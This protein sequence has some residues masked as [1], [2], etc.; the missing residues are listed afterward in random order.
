MS[1]ESVWRRPRLI[2]S[3]SIF[4]A[5]PRVI[6]PRL[7]A[8]STTSCSRSRLSVTLRSRLAR[9]SSTL[10]SRPV[11]PRA[12]AELFSPLSLSIS[13]FAFFGAL[14]FLAALFCAFAFLAFA[15]DFLEAFFSAIWSRL[16][17]A[18]GWGDYLT[19]ASSVVSNP[20]ST[21]AWSES[22]RARPSS[23]DL[24]PL[25]RPAA[26]AG[27]DRAM[28][29]AS[30][31]SI[32]SG[33]V[34]SPRPKRSASSS[35]TSGFWR[36]RRLRSPPK[37]SGASPANSIA[38][39]AASRTS[40]TASGGSVVGGVQVGDADPGGGAGQR[41]RPA[42]GP[43]L[44]DREP[45]PLDDP[46]ER[47]AA[48]HE[49]EVGAALAGGDQVR[50]EAGGRRAQG[51][52]AVARGQHPVRLGAAGL[53]Q[54]RGEAGRRLLQQRHVP[55]GA[56]EHGGELVEELAVDLDV[57]RVA[58]GDAEQPRA[59]GEERGVGREIA[60][61]E[62]VPGD[63]GELHPRSI[64]VLEARFPHRRRAGRVR[65]RRAARRG[66][67]AESRPALAPQRA[68]LS[69]AAASGS[70]SSG[71]RRGRGSPSRSASPSSARR[72]SSCAATNCSSRAA[73]RSATPGASSPATSTR[74]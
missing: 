19:T 13:A 49:G 28:P 24:A 56:G 68:A 48:P 52:E 33:A 18:G 63:G 69:T 26:P 40:A 65:A 37:S 6:R 9:N 27:R 7:T 15:F 55:G 58:L 10:L 74:S 54:R 67:R 25:G 35:K 36:G 64:R 70:S 59:P 21:G 12:A 4:S 32:A 57:G 23:L 31:W 14:A 46:A 38:A 5:S 8:S 62:E 2:M 47:S 39:R 34:G 20:A 61:V 66:A 72:R 42:L 73:S 71:P 1:R 30:R 11:A 45:A 29:R 3:E 41:H 44:V 16:L 51:A 43:A 60:P 53:R 50:V 22:R 17:I